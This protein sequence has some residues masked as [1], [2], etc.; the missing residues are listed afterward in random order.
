[1]GLQET[2]VQRSTRRCVHQTFLHPKNRIAHMNKDIRECSKISVAYSGAAL[3][4][5][6]ARA[7]SCSPI[8]SAEKKMVVYQR[9]S[10]W[11]KGTNK[12]SSST[13]RELG[14]LIKKCVTQSATLISTPKKTRANNA[15]RRYVVK[16][17]FS[18]VCRAT[19]VER[20]SVSIS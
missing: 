2:D 12:P 16:A 11:E 14:R 13:V 20:A 4:S 10:M 18:E 8:L 7:A 9:V 3:G 1:M 6:H 19:M 15:T 17:I 5:K